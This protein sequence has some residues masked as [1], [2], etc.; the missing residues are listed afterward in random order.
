MTSG[1]YIVVAVALGFLFPENIFCWRLWMVCEPC[2]VGK[3]SNVTDLIPKGSICTD[4]FSTHRGKL[5]YVTLLLVHTNSGFWY[6]EQLHRKVWVVNLDRWPLPWQ[7][8]LEERTELEVS[9]NVATK[10]NNKSK[11][12]SSIGFERTTV[13]SHGLEYPFLVIQLTFFLLLYII[14]TKYIWFC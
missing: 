5:S 12:S 3:R 6:T 8:Q 4:L 2:A 1:W 7:Q 9:F 10:L 13:T 11:S 14:L